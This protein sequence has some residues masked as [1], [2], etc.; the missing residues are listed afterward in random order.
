MFVNFILQKTRTVRSFG[1]YPRSRRP[2]V[3]HRIYPIWFSCCWPLTPRWSSG[4]RSCCTSFWRTTP[5]CPRSTWPGAFSSSWCTWATTFCPLEG[6]SILLY[7]RIFFTFFKN[8]LHFAAFFPGS[9]LPY[10]EVYNEKVGGRLWKRSRAGQQNDLFIH[11]SAWFQNGHITHMLQNTLFC[12]LKGF[13]H[14]RVF[15]W[16][17]PRIFGRLSNML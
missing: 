1:L 3:T 4:W 15:S 16:T 14:F 17:I 12:C 5:G 11:I 13:E 9:R 6:K 10:I 7:I 2:W 8:L